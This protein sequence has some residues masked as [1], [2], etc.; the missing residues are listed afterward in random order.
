MKKLLITASLLISVIA[1][2][3]FGPSTNTYF[4]VAGSTAANGFFVFNIPGVTNYNVP[5]SN[6]LAFLNAS[7]STPLPTKLDVTNTVNAIGGG[8][9]SNAVGLSFSFATAYTNNTPYYALF[10]LG[11]TTV[12]G[13]GTE[14]AVRTY[15]DFNGDGSVDDSQYYAQS[16]AASVT[17]RIVLNEMIPPGAKFTITN[18]SGSGATASLTATSGKITYISS[19]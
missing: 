6:M 11:A 13:A 14:G 18:F 2:A 12:N 1:F 10:Q 5:A 3:Q 7:A 15:I 9:V 19:Q 4:P 8:V 16:Y 17:V